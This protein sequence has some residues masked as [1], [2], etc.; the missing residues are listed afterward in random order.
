MASNSTNRRESAF[1]RAGPGDSFL[2][3]VKFSDLPGFEA[4]DHLAAWHVFARSCE[5]ASRKQTSIRPAVE[6][7]A[8]LLQV[9]H[10]T[11]SI[12]APATR[13]EARAY[14]EAHFSPWRVTSR[15]TPGFLT[16]Y[17]EPEVD[18]SLRSSAVFATPL[19]ARPDNLISPLPASEHSLPL[20]GISA[21]K[22]AA[23]GSLVSYDDRASI[24]QGS[25]GAR[26]IPIC[27]V[28]DNAE[29]FL[30]HIQGSARI[31]LSNGKVLRLTYDGR[32][33][34]PYSSIGKILISNGQIPD[35]E[36]SLARLKHWLRQDELRGRE[37]MR[38]NR[39]FIFFRIDHEAEPDEGP[40]GGAALRLT[41]LRSIAVDRTCWSY[42]LPFWIDAGLP[43]QADS[44]SAFQRLMV[45][46]DTGSAILGAARAD[47][48]FGCG[49][50]AGRRA[51]DIRHNGEFTVLLPKSGHK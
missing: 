41:P 10:Q 20:A 34:L 42:G 51:G 26:A 14:F 46:Q 44:T 27:W 24:E 29:A 11:Q 48:F 39:S 31:R 3:R 22:S 40:I 1:S 18:G 13:R 37:L 33:G 38:R 21:A 49:D 5:A 36:M 35:N 17:Y 15:Q 43:W 28:R 9:F 25:L 4:D 8:A 7:D 50:V 47:I 30:I 2:T 19:L 32:N 16:G 23:D 6:A 45:A 12:G